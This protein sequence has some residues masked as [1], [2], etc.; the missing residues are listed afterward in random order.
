MRIA[1]E[2]VKI[3]PKNI[4]EKKFTAGA[5]SATIWKNTGKDRFGNDV[6]FRTVTFDRRYKDRQGN[7][8]SSNSLRVNDL[9]KGMVVLEEAYKYLLLN[10]KNKQAY[11]SGSD[12][13]RQLEEETA[14]QELGPEPEI[15]DIQY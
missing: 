1:T 5:I 2:A 4:P 8:Q 9:P 11:E 6:T 15:E 13:G 3:E 7:W 10:T 14:G 12:L